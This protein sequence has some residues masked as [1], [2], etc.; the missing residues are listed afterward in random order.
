MATTPLLES[1][2]AGQCD[3]SLF[4]GPTFAAGDRPLSVTTGDF[5]G[6][7]VTD[8]ATANS[9]SDDVS[10]LLGNGDG[11]FAAQK[12]FAA[13]NGPRCVTTGDFNGDGLTDLATAN[14]NS[15]D[16]S[17]LLGN[18]DGTFEAP[19]TY[20][21][22]SLPNSVATGD[23]NGD[24]VTDLAT[25]NYFNNLSVLLGVGDGTFA[26][27]VLY[28]AGDG[29]RSV[30]TGDFNKDGFNDLATANFS[31]GELYLDNVSVLLGVGDGTFAAQAKYT[32]A[33]SPRSVTTG[34]FNGDGFIDLATTRYFGGKVTVL[35]N[36]SSGGFTRIVPNEL[37]VFRGLQI[38]GT[39]EN[40][41]E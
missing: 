27:Q 11:T 20:T 32:V 31:D 36:Q 21:V 29:P 33:D 26:A 19:A 12:K 35:L 7:G 1:T 24:C 13:T 16:V 38:G 9:Y 14:V 41:F 40:V 34:D 6:D 37:T 23:F 3:G 30:T 5:N 4:P 8:L 10:V 22:G 15:D 25:A 18:G 17:V 2:A 28:P 39:L